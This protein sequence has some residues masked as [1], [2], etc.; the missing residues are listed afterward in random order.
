MKKAIE[1]K[2]LNFRYDGRNVLSDISLDV[3]EGEIVGLFGHNGAGKT[4]LL[5]IFAEKYKEGGT[6][7]VPQNFRVFPNLTVKENILILGEEKIIPEFICQIFPTVKDK[8]NVL[9]GKLSGGEQQMV[10][11]ARAILQKPKILL[12]DEPSLGLSPIMAKKIF[13]TIKQINQNFGTT[14]LVAEHNILSLS[15]IVH[16]QFWL[17]RGKLKSHL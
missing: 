2:N 17:E 9:A 11:L 13:E 14:I 5:K 1:I 10:S 12:L 3:F 16:R 4:T 7:F 15:K 6:V 8:Q